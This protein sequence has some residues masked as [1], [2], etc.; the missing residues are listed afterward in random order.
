MFLVVFVGGVAVV[1][2]M[3]AQVVNASASPT[4]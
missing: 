3:L 2:W 1:A 4:R